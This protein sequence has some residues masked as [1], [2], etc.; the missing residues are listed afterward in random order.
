MK[1]YIV[2][3]AAIAHNLEVLSEK[4]GSAPIWA[5]LK[6]DGYGIGIVPMAKACLQAGIL[7]FAVTEVDEAAKLR[8]LSESAQILMLRPVREPEELEKMLEMNVIATVSSVEDAAVLNSIAN[9]LGAV[10]EA[11]V[12]IDTGMG[13]HGFLPHETEKMLSVYRH[14]DRIAVSGIYTHFHS[15]FGKASVTKQQAQRSEAVVQALAEAGVEPGTAHCCNSTAFLR[16]SDLKMGG[17]RLGS[18][19]LGRVPGKTNLR[20]VGWCEA[21]IDQLRWLPAGHTTGYGGAWRAK[22]PTRIAVIPVGW[23][24]GF[25]V[26]HGNDIFRFRDCL[27][28]GLNAL[29]WMM[30]PPKLQVSVGGRKC[31]VLGH[32][33]ML[34]TVCDVT[35]V[36]CNEGDKVRMEIKPLQVHGMEILW[37]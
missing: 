16:F 6:G 8:E 36:S 20:K 24:H 14:H 2:E 30:F 3:Q 32:V 33:G 15:A 5:V 18:A 17:V 10:A 25:G 27:R 31:K 11:H 4:A 13:R 37:K 26:E 34:H 9:Q 28:M 23:Y 21:T 1:Q 12:K 35:K 7:R 29:K 22:R 19:L